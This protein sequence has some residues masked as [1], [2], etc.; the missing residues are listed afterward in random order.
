MIRKRVW[1]SGALLIAAVLII[2]GW[3]KAIKPR[4]EKKVEQSSKVFSG[5]DLNQARKLEISK[6]AKTDILSLRGSQWVVETEGGYQADGEAVNKALEALKK[7]N[8]A[9]EAASGPSEFARF[10]LARDQ[11]LQVKIYTSKAEPAAQLF[12]GKRGATYASS[13]FRKE[14]DDRVCLAYENLITIFDRGS[15]TWRDK[16]IMEFAPTDCKTLKIEDGVT[17]VWLDKDAKE[18]K[19]VVMEAQSRLPAQSWAVDGIC[20]SLSKLKTQGF[21][22]VSAQEAGLEKPARKITATLVGG[23]N[24]TLMLGLS[25]KGKDNFYAKRQDLPVIFELSNWQ[26]SSLFKKKDE[27]LE[28]PSPEETAPEPA[29]GTPPMP[30]VPNP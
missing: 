13:Y 25:V 29:P 20:Q 8:C 9:T 28:K 16:K 2:I 24:Y 4:S 11:A 5:L 27:L 23:K 3:E 30:Q 18:S 1:V 17:V 15:D 14:G 6:G 21:P 10:E 12:I 26:I 22:L 19:W 7:L